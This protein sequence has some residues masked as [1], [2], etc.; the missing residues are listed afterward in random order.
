MRVFQEEMSIWVSKLSKQKTIVNA[1][2]Y[3][4]IHWGHRQ[5]KRAEQGW[6]PSLPEYLKWGIYFMITMSISIYFALYV[7]INVNQ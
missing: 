7:I 1:G 5:Y 4:P 6:I 2:R 3:H